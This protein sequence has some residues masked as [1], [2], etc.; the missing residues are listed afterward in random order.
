[1]AH[2]NTANFAPVIDA[3]LRTDRCM[4]LDLGI[5]SPLVSGDERENREPGLTNRV[6]ELMRTEERRIS[7]GQYDAPRLLYTSPLFATG[8][9]PEDEWRT[10]TSA[11][12]SSPTPALRSMHR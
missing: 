4:V 6:T 2:A 3:D 12:T 10:T 7:I 8:S 5:G 9:R 11:S 1:M